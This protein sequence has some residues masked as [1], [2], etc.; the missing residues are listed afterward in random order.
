VYNSKTIEPYPTYFA[1]KRA[2]Q[3]VLVS[4]E[5]WGRN[6]FAGEAIPT[7]FCIVNDLENGRTLNPGVV[8]W[9]IEGAGGEKIASGKVDV[10]AVG[11]YKRVWVTPN[12]KLP[13]NLKSSEVKAKLKLSY[14]EAGQEMSVNEYEIFIA[15]KTWTKAVKS[16]DKIV[17]VDNANSAES[18]D[19][20]QVK[21]T[22]ANSIATALAMNSKLIILSSISKNIPEADL[23]AI[24][25]YI[26]MGGKV[27]LLNSEDVSKAI[28]PE[29][30]TGWIKPT[31][32]DIVNMEIPESEVFD[33][34]DLLAL[35]Y[36]NN[37]KPELPKVCYN[38]FQVNRNAN[39]LELASHIKI[40]GYIKGEMSERTD[41]MKTIKGYPL[42]KIT[43][44]KGSAL[45]STMAH[46]KTATDPIA[47]KLLSN[48]INSMLK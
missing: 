34:I 22:K 18:L 17:L 37:N 35:R 36:F 40:H 21:Y 13:E 8:N 26:A 5:I 15:E 45:I 38:A 14:T 19:F 1:I 9:W 27:I 3:P 48:M 32:G 39:V 7:R 25:N 44:G 24:K 42:L 29:Y 10:S 23:K 12:I 33:N 28:F 20:I 4:T 41:Y 31:E 6:F 2:L 47:A 43:E 46:D 11:H 16:D 30:I